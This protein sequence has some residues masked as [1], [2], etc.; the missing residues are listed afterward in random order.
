MSSNLVEGDVF[1]SFGAARHELGRHPIRRRHRCDLPDMHTIPAMSL[2][3]IAIVGRPNVGKSSLLN[4]LAG[5]RVSIVDPTPGVTRDRVSTILE[6]DPPIDTPKGTPARLV[7]VFDTGGYG[8]YTAEGKRFNE[9]GEDLS[10]LTDDIERQIAAALDRADLILFVTDAQTGLAPLDEIIARML[11]DRGLADRVLPIANKV[12]AE[13]WEA[14]GLEAAALGFGAPICM[15]ATSGFNQRAML[16][17]V[18]ERLPVVTADTVAP[19]DD[20]EMKLAI[21]GKR[22][23][24]KSTLINA[25]AGEPRVIVSE[26]AGTTRDAVDVRFVIN[27]R[28][29][30]AIDTAG[31]RKKKSFADDVE[32]YAYRRMLGAIDRADVVALLIDATHDVSQVDKKLAQEL[33]DRFKPVVIVVNKADLIDPA[34]ATPEA[35]EDYLTKELGGV[36]FAPIVFTSATEGRGLRD[37]VAVALNLYDQA[38]HR[39]STGK[40][41]QA[42]ERILSERG[43]SSKLGTQAKVYFV[44]QVAVQP[45]TIV[46]VCNDPKLFHGQYER[47]LL[48]RLRDALPY[49]EI[50]IRLLFRARHRMDLEEMKQRGRRKAWDAAQD[51]ENSKSLDELEDAGHSEQADARDR[52]RPERSGRTA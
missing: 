42:I 38:R 47:Y 39:E 37:V 3:Q 52:G 5:R 18:Y 48:N 6:I 24:G 40:L 25:L 17:A 28:S 12:D 22:N 13:N 26:I 23:A 20:A 21:V 45:P 46:I 14:H 44:S 2:P 19:S 43:P 32:F 41:N 34:R 35:Y 15:S 4:R 49:S 27:D 10:R 16:E 7:E 51:A 9:I 30:L 29:F 1:R 31:M 50:P 8:V 33:Q 36:D 11:R